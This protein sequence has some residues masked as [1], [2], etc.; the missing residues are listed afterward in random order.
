MIINLCKENQLRLT[1]RIL[2][3]LL[4]TLLKKRHLG[5]IYVLIKSYATY[6]IDKMF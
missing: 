6:L 4:G 5:T 1:V 3:K 2:K